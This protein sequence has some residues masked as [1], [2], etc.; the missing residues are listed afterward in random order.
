[1]TAPRNPS[2]VHSVAVTLAVLLVMYVG[3]YYAMVSPV[4]YVPSQLDAVYWPR[5]QTD[6]G[7]HE[8]NLHSEI[9]DWFTQLFAPMNWLDRRIRPHVWKPS[10]RD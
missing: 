9:D 8:P 5:K 4:E 10:N 7:R 1:M 3:A 6:D 2:F